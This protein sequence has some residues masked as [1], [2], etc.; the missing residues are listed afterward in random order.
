MVEKLID[1]KPFVL[2]AVSE[3]ESKYPNVVPDVFVEMDDSLQVRISVL[4]AA[5]EDE[6]VN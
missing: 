1:I 4:P 2:E 3:F 5:Q 6:E